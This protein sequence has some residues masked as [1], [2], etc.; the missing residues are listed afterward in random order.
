LLGWP[1][2]ISGEEVAVGEEVVVGEEAV[3]LWELR[4]DPFRLV[5]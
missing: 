3:L 5:L 4:S 2:G 1:P